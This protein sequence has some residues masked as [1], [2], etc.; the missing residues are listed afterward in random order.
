[1]D[2]VLGGMKLDVTGVETEGF[3]KSCA[4]AMIETCYVL[5][6]WPEESGIHTRIVHGDNLHWERR[7]VNV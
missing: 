1:V 6:F 3:L 5:N 4:L 7:G 2:V